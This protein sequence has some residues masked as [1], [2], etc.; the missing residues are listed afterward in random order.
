MSHTISKKP[1]PESRSATSALIHHD[2]NHYR[3]EQ[4]NMSEFEPPKKKRVRARL[5]HLSPNEKLQRRK[6][7]NRIAAQTARDRK[8]AKIDHLEEENEKLRRENEILRI[9]LL[10]SGSTLNTDAPISINMTDS[11]VSDTRSSPKSSISSYDNSG[12]KMDLLAV[13][14]HS[15]RNNCLPSPGSSTSGAYSASTDT[16]N[17]D[18]LDSVV[19]DTNETSLIDDILRLEGSIFSEAGDEASIGSAELINGPQQQVQEV[20]SQSLSV[21]NS[22]G[23][24]SIQLM[25]LLMISRVHRQYRWRTNCCAMIHSGENSSTERVAAYSNLYD[26]IHQ[27]KCIDFRR[28]AEAIIFNKN[29]VQQQRI[30]ALEFMYIHLYDNRFR[31]NL[32]ARKNSLR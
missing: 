31:K 30:V 18:Y 27:T 5:D 19:V 7:K 4:A 2:Y 12:T 9:K 21:E 16:D 28:A 20:S 26:Y 13:P 24:T 32:L 11:G 6:M 8:R 25:L 17:H 14:Q 1:F 15:S 23:W 10:S 3:Q 22:A 29:N